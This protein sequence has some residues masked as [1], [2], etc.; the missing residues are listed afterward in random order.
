M[1]TFIILSYYPRQ[2]YCNVNE[3]LN[4]KLQMWLH[5]SS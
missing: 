2:L 5:H 3:D 4:Q 1:S